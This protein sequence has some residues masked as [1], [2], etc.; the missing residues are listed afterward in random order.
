M[1]GNFLNWTSDL[2]MHGSLAA[3][4][5]AVLTAVL[6]ILL[7]DWKLNLFAYTLQQLAISLLI[8]PFVGAKLALLYL[9]LMWLV[10][11]MLNITGHQLDMRNNSANILQR[12]NKTASIRENSILRISLTLAVVLIIYFLTRDTP[13]NWAIYVLTILG[14]LTIGLRRGLTI[15]LGLLMLLSGGMLL[16]LQGNPSNMV[17]TL[18]SAC[19]LAAGFIASVL[20]QAAPAR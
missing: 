3:V 1:I 16:L 20:L 11:L 19:M 12:L 14:V 10:A 13:L 4:I 8:T 5:L 18:A 9:C 15:S 7:P 6:L 2:A 17:I